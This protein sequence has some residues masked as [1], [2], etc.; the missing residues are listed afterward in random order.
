MKNME[1]VGTSVLLL[2][3]ML[4]SSQVFAQGKGTSAKG[5][6]G[7][8]VYKGVVVDDTDEPLPGV[9]I[10]VKGVDQSGG[11]GMATTDIDGKFL[12]VAPKG[13]DVLVFSYIGMK[14]K[15]VNVAGVKD[16]RVVME[17][18]AYTLDEAVVTG[19]QTMSRRESASAISSVKVEDVYLAGALSV[20][21]MLQGQVQGVAVMN[22]SGEPSATPKIRIRGTSTINGNKAPVWVVDGVILEQDVPITA[23]EL[24][25]DD[26]EYLVGNAISGISPQ[27][28]ESISVL[29]D[30][31]ATAIYGVKAANGVIVLTTKKG[32]A[33][34]PTVS[35]HGELV[36]TQK[37]S[38]KQYD[39]M[40]SAERMLLSKDIFE[41][42]LKYNSANS[43]NLNRTDS[44]EGLL[45]SLINR[46]IDRHQF[47]TEAMEMANRNTDWFDVLF[48]N[49]V[50]HNHNVNVTGGTEAAK[51]YFS[52][53]YNSNEGTAKGSKSNRFT[54]LAKVDVNFNKYVNFSAKIDYSTM[55]N[56]G[57]STV[58]PFTYAY[59]TSRTLMPYNN[60]GSYH[61]YKL[62]NGKMYNVL[63]ELDNTGRSVTN[64]DFNG[65]L[66]LNVNILPG[67]KYQGVF[68]YHNSTSSSRDWKTAQSN[69]VAMI[70][71]Y[72]YRE[73]DENDTDYWESALPYGGVLTQGYVQKT[74]YTV[75]NALN[76][77]ASFAGLHDINVYGGA[78]I[79]STKYKGTNVTGYG[80]VPEFGEQ[81]NPIYT[82]NF[83]NNYAA[84]G[85]LLPTNTNSHSR[86][87][88]FFG[89]AS[90][91]F[92]NRYV[93]NFNIR[94]DGANKFGSNPKYRWLP[95]WSVAGKWILTNEK[96]LQDFAATGNMIS[97]RG[98]Y[99]VQG[100]IHDDATPNLILQVGTRDPLSNL[101]RYNIYRIPNPDL[102]WE[103]T[104]S[105]NVALD[106]SL[107][108]GRLAGSFDVYNKR[109]EDLIMDKTV[110]TSTGR[111]RLY[112]NAGEMHNFGYEGNLSIGILRS[113]LFD[114]NFNLNFGHN[115][116]KVKLANTD[117][118]ST[119]EEINLM[120]N[121][122][123]PI[124]NEKLGMMYSFDYAGLSSED[125]YPLFRGKDGNLYHDGDPR[126]FVLVKSGSINPDLSGGFDTQL[127]FKKRLSLSIGFTYNLGG[128]KRLPAIYGSS[129]S[130][131]DPMSNVSTNWNNRWRN[132]GDEKFTD[133]PTLY[134]KQDADGFYRRGLR[135]FNPE[136]QHIEFCTYF[137]DR[138]SARVASADFL[139]LRLIGLTYRVPGE[140]LRH[141]GVSSMLLR[142]QA[143]NL[144]V[145]A[146][147]KW[148][149]LD[150]ETP[151]S[152]IPL[153]PTY[154][155]GLNISF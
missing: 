44:Y 100:N 93:A 2:L 77:I 136:D 66:N 65:L 15:E 9:T 119:Q 31:S 135:I 89:T 41:A 70:R 103:K 73:F 124:Q 86:V 108:N 134:N 155:F 149:G 141:I 117:F 21:Q 154:S 138:S 96:F 133:V 80:W 98:S 52:A 68:S 11:I 104:K 79:R 47:A 46:E 91:T 87:A 147:K 85:R 148:Q 105:W 112:I 82:T 152:N 78:E 76:Y 40:N 125:G 118:Y 18:D 33:G 127:T 23:S 67:L 97:V 60:D 3:M 28:I 55:T 63:N 32:R 75:R 34:K 116:N 115:D 109:T 59:K 10:M 151:E 74:G 19:Y 24:N 62:S 13:K 48:R 110:A 123:I 94:S 145:W 5:S 51:Y 7:N 126:Q 88:S 139:R 111:S 121:G 113:Q 39:R 83:T 56:D 8:V 49:S 114:W 14:K 25:S 26:A 72:E 150:P 54:A 106:F 129:G 107:F 12:I 122:N 99:G 50:T 58:N 143:S 102:R 64:N 42:G 146:S 81:F 38:Y 132:P 142:A 35:Y 16:V 137:Y 90:Y 17:S 37:P 22:S 144:H 43:M 36:V 20:D 84:A 1:R 27:D 101:D 95:T 69:A 140:W 71:G 61:M 128:V 131:M 30:A 53:G 153:S 6:S 92:D 57:Y 4:L 120:L 29:K 130:A 45:N